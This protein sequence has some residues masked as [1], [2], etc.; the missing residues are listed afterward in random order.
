MNSRAACRHTGMEARNLA[1][2]YDLAPLDW[3]TIA[4]RLDQ[5]IPQAP[6]DGGP[7][8]HTCWLA[9]INPDGSP[10]VN[11]VGAIWADGA[12][13]F[14]TGE[15]SRKA[16]NLARDPRCT[17]SV[18]TDA[19]DLVVDGD[20]RI[21]RDRDVVAARAA[22]WRAGGWP[23]VVDAS[24]TALT[25]EYSAPSAGPPPWSVYRITPHRAT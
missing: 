8:R 12:F 11:G 4:A 19:F 6:G 20:A 3:A 17:I 5:G 7:N 13:W 14:E 21:V 10:H 15:Q 9:T 1:D 22:D 23:C 18:A 16:R 25:A 24:G 2:L